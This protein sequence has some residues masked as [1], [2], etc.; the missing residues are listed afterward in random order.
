MDKAP[1]YKKPFWALLLA[2]LAVL[3]PFATWAGIL[4]CF[5]D[6]GTTTA[7]IASRMF[8]GT[9]GIGGVLCVVCTV[10]IALPSLAMAKWKNKKSHGEFTGQIF[11]WSLILC[12][13]IA[14][15]PTIETFRL[16]TFLLML[17]MAMIFLCLP[18]YIAGSVFWHLSL[19]RSD[20]K[21]HFYILVGCFLIFNILS[22]LFFGLL[23][24]FGDD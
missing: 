17:P 4:P 15:L 18:A 13:L 10:F 9:I 23:L 21:P 20:E 2:N 11:N 14:L 16:N 8:L 6:I 19:K 5:M 12:A 22:F 24:S 1:L 3:I 7:D